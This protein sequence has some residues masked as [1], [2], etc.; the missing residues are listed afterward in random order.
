[1]TVI[2]AFSQIIKGFGQVP[3]LGGLWALLPDTIEYGEWKTGIR[4]EGLLYSGGSMGQ[5]VGVGLGSAILGWVL[6]AGGYIGGQIEQ[7][8]TAVNAI[9]ILFIYLPII[10]FFI[11]I[12]LL[13]FY[14]LDKIYPKI[15]GD[16]AKRHSE[17]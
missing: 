16:L 13:Y 7:P 12:I 15:E 9:F 3:L 8:E 4:N 11:Q 14:K 1:N 6:S 2:V 10:V 5:K 17:N